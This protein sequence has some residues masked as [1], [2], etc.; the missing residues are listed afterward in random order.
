MVAPVVGE[1]VTNRSS[2]GAATAH[3]TPLRANPS[4]RLLLHGADLPAGLCAGGFFYSSA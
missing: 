2:H 4:E 1:V 3:T